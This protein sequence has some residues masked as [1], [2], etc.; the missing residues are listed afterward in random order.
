MGSGRDVCQVTTP[1]TFL[2]GLRWNMENTSQRSWFPGQ[3]LN[4]GP[5]D[6]EAG[7]PTPEPRP[8]LAANICKII[9]CHY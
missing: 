8:T 1:P 6:Y 2:E 5:R 7:V 4:L 9:L 3:D